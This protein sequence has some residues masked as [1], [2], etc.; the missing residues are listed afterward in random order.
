MTETATLDWKIEPQPRETQVDGRVVQ[1]WTLPTDEAFL[2]GFLRDVFET[3]WANIVFGP[4]IEGAA[5]EMTC[6]RE[7]DLSLFDGYLTVGF[8]G[9][10][11]HLCVGDS[12]GDPGRP[13]PPALRT[14][15]RPGTARIF[16]RLDRD[17]APLA[18]GFEMANGADEPMITIF[19]ASPFLAA[20]DRLIDPPDWSRLAMWRDLAVRYLGRAPEAFDESGKGWAGAHD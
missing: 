15:R 7:P 12:L 13:A 14:R 17:G 4:M 8:R 19:F 10:H 6:P 5:Y 3:Y 16:R 2:V 20:G 18:W 11:F 1:L 9:A